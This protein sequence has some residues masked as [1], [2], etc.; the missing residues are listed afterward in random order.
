MGV[1]VSGAFTIPKGYV[2]VLRSFTFTADPVLDLLCSEVLI[3][4]LV[5]NFPQDGYTNMELGSDI[6]GEEIPTFILVR[7]GQRITLKYD[8]STAAPGIS[9]LVCARFYGNLLLNTGVP[10][11]YQIGNEMRPQALIPSRMS[12]LPSIPEVSKQ[13]ATRTAGMTV[14]RARGRP[15][16]RRPRAMPVRRRTLS[17]AERR[18]AD[19]ARARRRRPGRAS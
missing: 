8:N 11:E 5:N 10:I 14:G 12:P 18:R 13:I 19:I 16:R 9:I 17:V 6:G 15:A 7:E 1:A 3:T 2:G 4:I